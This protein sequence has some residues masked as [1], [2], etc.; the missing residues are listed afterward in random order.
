MPKMTK[1]KGGGAARSTKQQPEAA[2]GGKKQEKV[3]SSVWQKDGD[4]FITI[5]AKPGAKQSCITDVSESQVSIQISA[6]AHEGEANSELVQTLACILGVR[7]SSVSIDHGH[8][9]REKRVR[10]AGCDKDASEVFK[11]L[12][13]SVGNS[14]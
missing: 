13:L 2:A 8:R 1:S 12:Q 9:S 5:H 7:K 11:V 14:V 3:A 4:I 6:P 10:L